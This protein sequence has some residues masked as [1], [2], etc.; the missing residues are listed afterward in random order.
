V[1]RLLSLPAGLA[2]VALSAALYLYYTK[3][4]LTLSPEELHLKTVSPYYSG[5][6]I[7][8]ASPTTANVQIKK[9][10]SA[11]DV[12]RCAPKALSLG[13]TPTRIHFREGE[14]PTGVI[15]VIAFQILESGEVVNI[16]LKQSS[17][18]RDKDNAALDWVKGSRYNNRPGCGT[19]ETEVGVTIDLTAQ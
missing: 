17:G 2:V 1:K 18:I 11:Y 9:S 15:P 5:L 13:K 6:P 7:G 8:L 10:D 4:T 14:K 12:K 3:P 16:V 19:V